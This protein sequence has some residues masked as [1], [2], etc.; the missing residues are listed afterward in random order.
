MVSDIVLRLKNALKKPLPG[1]EAQYRMAPSSRGR[2]P[3]E[4]LDPSTITQGAVLILLFVNEKDIYFPLIERVSYEGPH[5]WQI[6]L[7]GGKKDPQDFSLEDTALRECF[8]EIG[9]GQEIEILGKLTSLYI[10]VSKFLV[11]PYVAACYLKDPEFIPHQREVKQVIR[12]KLTDLISDNN[13]T[14]GTVTYG[15]G[16]SLKCPYYLVAEKQVWGATAMIL[17]ELREVIKTT[18]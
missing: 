9:I 18:S 1:I 2:F 12:M 3:V 11:E 6:S 15:N 4:T 16:L 13:G 17:S 7:P 10:P 14:V 5:G 8:E